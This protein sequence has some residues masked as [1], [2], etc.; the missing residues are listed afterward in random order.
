MNMNARTA[1]LSPDEMP[2]KKA[3]QFREVVRRFRKNKLAMLGFAIF[4]MIAFFAI[5][6][7]LFG[8]YA[9][10]TQQVIR[11]KL[12]APSAAHWFGT[13]ELGR[14]LFLRCIYGARV[15]LVI[16]ICASALCFLVGGALGLVA[17]YNEGWVDNVIMR[18]LDILSSLPTILMAIC[19][20]AALGSSIPNLVIA[21][22]LS[23][24]ASFARITRAS[25]LSET[26][27]DYIE[28]ARAGGTPAIR[29]LVK[30][31][32]PNILGSMLVQGTTNVAQMILDVAG[33]SFIGL[34]VPSPMPEWGFIISTAKTFM[35]TKTYLVV[36]PAV[37]VVLAALSINMIGD[38]L[39]DALDPRLKS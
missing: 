27:R 22:A 35:R 33:M 2:A 25:A 1:A 10:C 7:G 3:S 36:L 32:F 20:V 31:I 19:I 6:A 39:R 15:S 16:G 28:A 9:E 18:A 38:G 37:C 23:R 30:Q 4:L 24:I 34:G 14:D 5:F 13:D 8:T 26:G 11:D 12:Q 29:I 21:L 17:A